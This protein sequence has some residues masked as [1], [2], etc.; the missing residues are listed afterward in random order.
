MSPTSHI[1]EVDLCIEQNS[2]HKT[3]WRLKLQ[4]I[5]VIFY[6]Q[7]IMNHNNAEQISAR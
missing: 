2:N 5:A 3:S 7:V 6:R 4:L 1:R